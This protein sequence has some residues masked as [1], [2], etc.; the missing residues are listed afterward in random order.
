M[1]LTGISSRLLE[2]VNEESM[3]INIRR[4]RSIKKL[5]KKE[6]KNK[7]DSYTI[8]QE[9]YTSLLDSESDQEEIYKINPN[10]I[11]EEAP[12]RPMRAC[13]QN[14]QFYSLEESSGSEIDSFYPECI[15]ARP[16]IKKIKTEKVDDTKNDRIQRNMLKINN[17]SDLDI[18]N[19]VDESSENLQMD[20]ETNIVIAHSE[21]NEPDKISIDIFSKD[22]TGIKANETKVSLDLNKEGDNLLRIENYPKNTE[23]LNI[24]SDSSDNNNQ[25]TDIKSDPVKSEVL[26]EQVCQMEPGSLMILSNTTPT[27][28]KYFQV[29][30]VTPDKKRVPIDLSPD[31]VSSLTT[32]LGSAEE[33]SLDLPVDNKI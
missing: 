8:L 7:K 29:Y 18:S 28:E 21:N 9:G 27:G 1:L 2:D 17:E 33:V 11:N 14:A 3:A 31:V 32:S 10:E 25:I 30:M 22:R 4:K 26:N 19:D 13:R 23:K 6:E 5:M 12:K 16:K 20:V 15:I 24:K